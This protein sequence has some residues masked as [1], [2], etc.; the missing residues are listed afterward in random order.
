MPGIISMSLYYRELK[1]IIKTLKYPEKK[2]DSVC[3]AR[4]V[5]IMSTSVVSTNES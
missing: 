5:I 2:I 3:N 4:C 1:R